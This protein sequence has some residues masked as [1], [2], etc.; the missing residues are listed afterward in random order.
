[1]LDLFAQP[2]SLLNPKTKKDHGEDFKNNRSFY[3][4]IQCLMSSQWKRSDGFRNERYALQDDALYH[5][6][7]NGLFWVM[8]WGKEAPHDE[9]RKRSRATLMGR[10]FH[11]LSSSVSSNN[12]PPPSNLYHNPCWM[13]CAELYG[14]TLQ[15]LTI[16]GSIDLKW[17]LLEQFILSVDCW[18]G[19]REIF[20]WGLLSHSL[21]LF[22][23]WRLDFF[24]SLWSN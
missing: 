24:E 7:V 6:S 20:L 16:Q 14:F 18:Q 1:M 10:A 11:L 21:F 8:D 17:L 2:I 9:S 15:A 19:T 13:P 5:L 3:F 4:R 23:N 22:C 12:P